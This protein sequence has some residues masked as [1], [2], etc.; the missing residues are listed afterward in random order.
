MLLFVNHKYVVSHVEVQHADP[1]ATKL[2]IYMSSDFI[3]GRDKQ[4][5]IGFEII[6]RACKFIFLAKR[7]RGKIP[8]DDVIL[9][10]RIVCGVILLYF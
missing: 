7:F 4:H 1:N 8:I 5:V 6:N 2:L 10:Y 9:Y 3:F